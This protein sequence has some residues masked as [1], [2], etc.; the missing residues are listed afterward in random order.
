M[1]MK[2]ALSDDD[3]KR[4]LADEYLRASWLTMMNEVA[5]QLEN[6]VKLP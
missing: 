1:S 2:Y 5:T 4:F 6:G 3:A